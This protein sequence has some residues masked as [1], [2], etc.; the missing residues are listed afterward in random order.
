[1]QNPQN[2][3]FLSTLQW[4]MQRG[5]TVCLL[6]V[7]FF[8]LPH[9][10]RR[11]V[12][13]T[14]VCSASII[15]NVQDRSDWGD[16]RWDNELCFHKQKLCFHQQLMRDRI[17]W[18]TFLN[19]HT[20]GDC[21]LS[22]IYLRILCSAKPTRTVLKAWRYALR[23]SWNDSFSSCDQPHYLQKMRGATGGGAASFI[24]SNI[25][26][27]LLLLRERSP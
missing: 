16:W 22:Q 27:G 4:C 26:E 14:Q 12:F 2:A 17:G 15:V 8:L 11:L 10:M 6:K 5:L 23:T 9:W 20:S 21:A 13:I 1:M 7:F 19:I 3:S 24:L 25:L 18:S